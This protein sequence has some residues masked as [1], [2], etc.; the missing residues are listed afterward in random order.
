M[1]CFPFTLD[2]HC[3]MGLLQSFGQTIMRRNSYFLATVLVGAFF[4][5]IA[6]DSGVEALWEWNNRGVSSLFVSILI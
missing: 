3:S 6:V 5:E 1:I 2:T 4:T